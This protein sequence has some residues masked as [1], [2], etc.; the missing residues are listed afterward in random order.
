VLER[1]FPEKEPVIEVEL[2]EAEITFPDWSV[3]NKVELELELDSLRLI[4]VPLVDE[5]DVV[6][7]LPVRAVS[8]DIRL[9]PVLS[10][11]KDRSVIVEDDMNSVPVLV[12]PVT[13]VPVDGC[14]MVV[15]ELVSVM[16]GPALIVDAVP[17][18]D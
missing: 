16:V 8:V 3:V 15:I 4:P 2:E 1:A 12:S 5:A 14:D 10:V 7:P 6:V 11:A 13:S 18:A 9:V 17:V